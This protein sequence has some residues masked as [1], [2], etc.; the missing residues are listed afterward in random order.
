METPKQQARAEFLKLLRRARRSNGEGISV[1]TLFPWQTRLVAEELLDFAH[2][3]NLQVRILTGTACEH[4]Y[5]GPVVDRLTNLLERGIQVR[6]LIWNDEEH[7]HAPWLE[8]LEREYESLEVKLTGTRA[9]G[10]EISHFMVVGDQAYR[11]EMAHP[12]YDR[13]EFEETCPEI[14]ATTC[15]CDG[16]IAKQLETTFDILWQE[17]APYVIEAA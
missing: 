17:D 13:H 11:L 4:V 8:A 12:Y 14:K 5:T 16:S 2:E 6:V 15:F 9:M 1:T 3:K 7:G 10:E